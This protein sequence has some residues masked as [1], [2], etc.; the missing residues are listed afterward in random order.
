M[1]RVLAALL[2]LCLLPA[3]ALATAMDAYLS[4]EDLEALEPAYEAFVSALADT[5]NLPT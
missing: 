3:C 2:A 1:K 5:M 4:G